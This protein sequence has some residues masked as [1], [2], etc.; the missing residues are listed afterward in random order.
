MLAQLLSGGLRVVLIIMSAYPWRYEDGLHWVQADIG[1][2]PDRVVGTLN[3]FSG[4]RLTCIGFFSK[5][6][7]LFI[8]YP[9]LP[10][11]L[12]VTILCLQALDWGCIVADLFN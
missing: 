12:Q 5:L 10:I 1:F 7:T 11:P 2:Y 4:I 8:K 6:S 9:A 3:A